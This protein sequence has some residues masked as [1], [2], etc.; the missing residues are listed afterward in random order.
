MG[1]LTS[2]LTSLN[3]Y[4]QWLVNSVGVYPSAVWE[5]VWKRHDHLTFRHTD[6]MLATIPVVMKSLFRNSAAQLFQPDFLEVRYSAAVE[7]NFKSL[8]PILTFPGQQ[9]TLGFNIGTRTNGQD[10]A[11]WPEDLSTEVIV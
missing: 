10:A 2:N 4:S 7:R 5:D 9:V 8:R 3:Y 1:M 11:R 6:N